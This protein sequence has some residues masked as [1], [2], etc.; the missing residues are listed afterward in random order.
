MTSAAKEDSFEKLCQTFNDLAHNTVTGPLLH[1]AFWS[2]L[3]SYAGPY[4]AVPYLMLQSTLQVGSGLW[5]NILRDS[6]N[7]DHSCLKAVVITGC[8]HG[9]GRDMAIQAVKAGYTV[10]AGCL[11][12][13]AAAKQQ[14][15][16]LYAQQQHPSIVVVQ[17]DVTNQA[18]VL[19]LVKR[20]EYWVREEYRNGSQKQQ[21]RVLHA[22]VNNAGI[23][24][25]GD[26]EWM[27]I[28]DFQASMDG[29][30]RW[31]VATA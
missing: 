1:G 4:L 22:L 17:C 13:K 7:D 5:C 24:M 8:D 6:N 31:I 12:A 3:F 28:K 16:L 26:V 23:A 21:Q 2:S 15:L 27:D 19:Q 18:Q 30:L 29:T 11:N 20:V 25:Q 10:F 14:Q 9:L